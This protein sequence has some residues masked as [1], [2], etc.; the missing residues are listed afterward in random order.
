MVIKSGQCLSP[1]LHGFDQWFATERSAPTF[2]INCGCFP[3]SRC[4][5]GHYSGRPPC[6]NYYT[7]KSGD[8]EGWPEA[9]PEGDSHFIYSLA[10]KY[11]KEQVNDHKPFFLYLPFHAVHDRY[12]AATRYQKMYQNQ[13]Y[14]SDQIDYN[15]TISE[16]DDVMGK[17]R[18]LLN[19]LGIKNNTLLWFSSDNG[20]KVNSPGATNGLRGRKQFLYEGGI[21][22]PGI[23]EWPD[24]ITSNKVSSFPIVSNDLL[25]TVRDIL[26]IKPT[27]NRPIDGI[28]IL[29]FLQGKVEHRNQS[30]YWGFP[31]KKGFDQ[32]FKYNISTSGDRYKLMATYEH[33]KVTHHELYDLTNDLGETRDLSKQYPSISNKLLIEIEKWRQS[34]MES[35]QKVGCLK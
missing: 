21:R 5:N 35:V 23:I 33:G 13:N 17:L 20:P 1:G 15:G 18:E 30:I 6:T 9:I 11:I 29:P 31:I 34:V 22:V 7:N 2:T 25:P 12:V 4:I 16:M 32:K 26:G 8:I 19:N 3:N 14:N 28:S 10:E 24:V 27:D